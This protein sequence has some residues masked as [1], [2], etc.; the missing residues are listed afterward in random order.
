MATIVANKPFPPPQ[1][2]KRPPPPNLQTTGNGAK[3]SNPSPSPSSAS[4][5]LPGQK[6]PPAA[7]LANGALPNGTNA[8]A[9]RQRKE[10][11]RAGDS[12]TRLRLTTRS[13]ALDGLGHSKA[14]RHPEPH[15]AFQSKESELVRAELIF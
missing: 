3:A 11:A 2:I 13:G 12:T 15:G 9:N 10:S 6:Q 1:K 4:K 8:R 5:R 14:Q 7:N